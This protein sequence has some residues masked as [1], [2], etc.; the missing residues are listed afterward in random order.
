LTCVQGILLAFAAGVPA[1]TL[2]GWY[3]NAKRHM[4]AQ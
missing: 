4:L 2:G 1:E 3:R